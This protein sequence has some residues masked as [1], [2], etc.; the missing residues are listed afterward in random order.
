MKQTRLG[1][2]LHFF[3]VQGCQVMPQTA[4]SDNANEPIGRPGDPCVM[5]I[6]GASGDLTRRK[7]IPALY[8]LGKNRLLSREFAVVGVARD[9]LT[10]EDFRAKLKQDLQQFSDVQIDADLQEWFQS[11]M[12]YLQGEFGDAKTFQQL[13]DMLQKIDTDHGTHQNY[14]YY[15]AIS[16]D[17]F[18]PVVEQLSSVG[19]L[20]EENAHWRRVIV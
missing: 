12:Y 14:F 1:R 6:F 18:G 5:V 4:R 15:L 9:P 13:K 16:P 10:T 7:S 8:N 17:F 2:L 3:D 11:R 19:L 20:T